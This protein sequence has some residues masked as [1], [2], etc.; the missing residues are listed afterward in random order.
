MTS[1]SVTRSWGFRSTAPCCASG[2]SAVKAA[3]VRDVRFHDLRHTFATSRRP[4]ATP[5]TCPEQ[6]GELVERAFARD[7]NGDIKV[8]T[9]G[10]T[11]INSNALT[12]HET[13]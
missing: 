7:I 12:T 9:N 4:S 5:T 10:S 11:Q 13:A 6:E 3:K 2:S 1:C 8:Q